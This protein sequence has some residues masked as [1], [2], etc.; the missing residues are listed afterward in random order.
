[1]SSFLHS[2]NSFLLSRC[3]S[4]PWTGE[5]RSPRHGVEI[6]L[7][8]LICCSHLVSCFFVVCSVLRSEC[9]GLTMVISHPAETRSEALH[10]GICKSS[11]HSVFSFIQAWGRAGAWQH[12]GIRRGKQCRCHM[13]V[14]HSAG[15]PLSSPDLLTPSCSTSSY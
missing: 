10:K 13:S 4:F 14:N 12:Q 8:S 3:C 2:I 5:L 1:M 9:G 7:K 11:P 15:L 6:I